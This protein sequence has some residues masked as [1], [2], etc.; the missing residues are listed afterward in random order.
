[1][2]PEAFGHIAFDAYNRSKGGLT[3][4]GKKIPP[5]EDLPTDVRKAWEASAEAVMQAVSAAVL[6]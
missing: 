4:D 5:W 2:S 6:A 3:Y 1:M